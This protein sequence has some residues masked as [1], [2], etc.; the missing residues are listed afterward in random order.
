MEY[1]SVLMTIYPDAL[2]KGVK[3]RAL[4]AMNLIKQKCT[5]SNKGR[6]CA[7]GA[8]H[9]K[10]VPREEARS[11]NLSL[12][13]LIMSLTI[14]AHECQRVTVFDVPVASLQTYLPKDK[15]LLLMLEDQFWDIMCIINPE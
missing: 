11:P 4:R 15:F 5:G 3:Q 7:N 2:T 8:P 6:M 13:V 14:Y 1:M 10:F 12:E 9:W